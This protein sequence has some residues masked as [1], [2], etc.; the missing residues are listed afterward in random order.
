M[1]P[2]IDVMAITI[3]AVLMLWAIARAW[4]MRY[5]V[6]QAGYCNLLRT[7]LALMIFFFAGYLFSIWALWAKHTDW[8]HSIVAF[9]FLF[10]SV[11]VL[12]TVW[13]AQNTT[14]KLREYSQHLEQLVEERTQHLQIA[15]R[16]QDLARRYFAQ[17]FQGMPVACFTYDE[18]GVIRDWNTEAE[19]VYGFTA[20]EA[21]GKTIYELF[22]RPENVEATRRV[23]QRVFAGES[24]R[25]IEWQDRTKNGEM[26]W[27]L[28]STFPFSDAEGNVLGAIS[29]NIDITERKRQQEIIEAQRDELEAQ[30]ESLRQ[31]TAR[32]A[33]AN[34]QMERM[35]A[36]DG[37]TGLPN[38]RVFRERL[39]REFLW[40]LERDRAMSLMLMDV[41]HFKSF[42]DTFGHQAGD[43]VL[44]QV[45]SVLEQHCGDRAFPA[46][47]GG[48]EFVAILPEMD[49]D[50]AILFAEQL[51]EAIAA[52]P[53]CYRQ[54]TASIGVATVDLHTLNPDSLIEEA[55]QALYAS[56][57]RGRNRVSHAADESIS[58]TEIPPEEWEERVQ[59][60]IREG[61]GYAAQQVISQ[62]IYD[63]L[64]AMRRARCAVE[65]ADPS[66]CLSEGKCRFASWQEY[67]SRY[68]AFSSPR[69]HI[70]V[71]QHERFHQLMNTLRR[72]PAEEVFRELQ[73]CGRQ[74]V[75]NLHEVLAVIPCAA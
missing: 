12:L 16:E 74:L 72:Q 55:D 31:M 70:V 51:R 33:E 73:Q 48:E 10:G 1:K 11:F 20:E 65:T 25:G 44:R 3:G 67:A 69:L 8:L 7:L 15:L 39:W 45:A 36:T 53:C 40:S 62:L 42:N 30:N 32:L 18:Q 13:L 71:E 61:G 66:R 14:G 21:V 64:Q 24:L 75:D 28:T 19:R 34:A 5:S 37:L 63:H 35:A 29:A 60:A 6:Q 26:R 59:R 58:I 9:V 49:R 43:E 50:T 56:K 41:D 57:R 27:M 23:I 68:P 22:C 52:A 4:S 2:L 17:L 38:H 47:Y 46:R 54:I